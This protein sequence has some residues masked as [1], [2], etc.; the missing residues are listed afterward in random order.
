MVGTGWVT[1]GC[2]EAL[3]MDDLIAKATRPLAGKVDHKDKVAKRDLPRSN[4]INVRGFKPDTSAIAAPAVAAVAPAPATPVVEA[5]PKAMPS[6]YTGGEAAS[7]ADLTG[8]KLAEPRRL[9]KKA[10]DALKASGEALREVLTDLH[11]DAANREGPEAD[12]RSR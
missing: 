4:P 2:G 12:W 11:K 10:P 8:V 1:T 7:L 5:A 6:A 9:K 3:N